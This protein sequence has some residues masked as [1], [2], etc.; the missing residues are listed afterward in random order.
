MQFISSFTVIICVLLVN[1]IIDARFFR[2]PLRHIESAHDK[3][4][5][6]GAHE[7][8]S[9]ERKYGLNGPVPEDLINY[10][11][12]QYYGEIGIG[13]P[14]QPFRVV[15]DTGSSNLWV[16]SINCPPSNI[17]CLIHRK[18]DSKKSSTYVANGT[19]FEIRYGTGSLSG[20]VSVDTVTIDGVAVKNQGFAEALKQPGVT[21]IAAK[22]D[23]I[24][25]LAYPSISVDGIYPVF[26][27][28]WDQKLVD[29][30]VFG[31][32]LNRDPTSPRG[33]EVI[34]GGR[35]PTL[36]EG[37]FTYLN[38]TRE[39][40]WQF[41]LDGISFDSHSY[42]QGGCQAIAD[43]GTSLLV[44]PT[45]EIANLNAKLGAFPLPGGEYVFNCNA[46]ASLP[47]I[48]FV[49][50]GKSFYL[51]GHDYVLEVSQFNQTTCLSGFAGIDI[52]PPAGPLWILGDVFIGAWYTE[53][54]FANNRVGFAKSVTPKNST[55]ESPRRKASLRQLFG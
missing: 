34:F 54:D 6:A 11:D 32:W 21:F 40:Y 24:L 37:D 18:Y 5:K 26:N 19:D 10:M 52:P 12:A 48:S 1:S 16:P 15:F 28:M 14:P 23:G 44:G 20:Y 43:S 49:L 31:F 22:F 9:F 29:E 39:K 4:F 30:N 45:A 33:G 3:L 38:V 17:A 36:F 55:I 2:I 51:D 53:F 25:G 41:K 7:A 8:I 42:C 46:T 13:T 35:D 50:N 47:R 27:N